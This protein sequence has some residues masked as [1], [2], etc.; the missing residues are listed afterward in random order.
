MVKGCVE[1]HILH[2]GED[3]GTCWREHMVWS[4]LV[5][6]GKTRGKEKDGLKVKV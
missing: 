3:T 6:D 4:H 2:G 5:G 1:T